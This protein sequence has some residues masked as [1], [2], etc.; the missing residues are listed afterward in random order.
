MSKAVFCFNTCWSQLQFKKIKEIMYLLKIQ[1]IQVSPVKGR[2]HGTVLLCQSSHSKDKIPG[3]NSL[4]F[5]LFLWL[6]IQK[7]LF[8]NN[9]S[10]LPNLFFMKLRQQG[11]KLFFY[12]SGEIPNYNQAHRCWHFRFWHLSMLKVL[13]VKRD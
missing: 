11:V 5:L 3:R 1:N 2:K 4:I 12:F 10:N 13:Y 9:N 8:Q 6:R 7:N